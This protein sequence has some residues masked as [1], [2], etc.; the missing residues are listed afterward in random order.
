MRGIG[1]HP[2]TQEGQPGAVRSAAHPSESDPLCPIVP[3]EPV[4]FA[5]PS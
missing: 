4:P 5:Y 3:L 2:W 1:V